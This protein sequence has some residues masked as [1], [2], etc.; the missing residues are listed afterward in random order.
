MRRLIENLGPIQ[1]TIQYSWLLELSRAF[2]DFPEGEQL[3]TGNWEQLYDTAAKKMA[4]PNWPL[5]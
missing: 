3:T 4:A 5:V 2:F 1:N